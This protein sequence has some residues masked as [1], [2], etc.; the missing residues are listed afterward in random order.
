M[1]CN[2]HSEKACKKNGVDNLMRAMP[3]IVEKLG[4]K[5]SVNFLGAVPNSDVARYLALAEIINGK[6]GLLTDACTSEKR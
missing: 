2:S 1:P 3:Q 5:N 4:I 6:N